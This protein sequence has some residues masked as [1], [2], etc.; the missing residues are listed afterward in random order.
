[1]TASI[2]IRTRSPSRSEQ[3]HQPLVPCLVHHHHYHTGHTTSD[4]SSPPSPAHATRRPTRAASVSSSPPIPNAQIVTVPLRPCCAD[5]ARS[6][7]ACL[8]QGADWQEHFT[9]GALRLRRRASLS[10]ANCT[11]SS[12]RKVCESVPG[13]GSV[14]SKLAVDEVDKIGKGMPT[15]VPTLPVAKVVHEE[16][17]DD[18]LM[19]SLSRTVST[20]RV[21]DTEKR[22][23]TAPPLHSKAYSVDSHRRMHDF[24]P[25]DENLT[26]S[27]APPDH[28]GSRT[29]SVKALGSSVAPS[30]TPP[31]SVTSTTTTTTMTTTTV[32]STAQPAR[33]V[34]PSQQALPVGAS[35]TVSTPLKSQS[36]FDEILD[37][38]PRSARRPSLGQR[39]T[40]IDIPA[41]STFFKAGAEFLK[42]VSLSAGTPMSL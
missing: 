30:R 7:E 34:T 10:D 1:M 4:P 2:A 36:S 41:P 42:G 8:M 35:T 9:R 38:S 29:R 27:L 31:S 3:L 16:E 33:I 28:G 20:S 39:W 17:A 21:L 19:P 18:T 12:Q 15:R 40:H 6:I 37:G 13:F 5:C 14:A 22:S 26:S 11:Y 23:V 25:V 24:A 32:L